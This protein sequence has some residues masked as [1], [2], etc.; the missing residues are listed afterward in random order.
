MQLPEDCIEEILEYLED[1]IITLHSCSLVSRTLCKIAIP[2][3]WRQPFRYKRHNPSSALIETYWNF[4]KKEYVTSEDKMIL[5]DFGIEI[6]QQQLK[7]KK[8]EI[9]NYPS[10][11][12]RLNS[13]DLYDFS[14]IWFI[15]S[16]TLVKPLT[17]EP[18]ITIA[19]CLFNTFIARGAK[20]EYLFWET[21]LIVFG[22]FVKYGHEQ[23]FN[24]AAIACHEIDTLIIGIRMNENYSGK[25]EKL[26]SLN[27]LI[28][29]Q[30]KLRE[31]I[32]AEYP[33]CTWD[34]LT[35]L[36]EVDISLDSQIDT[37][38]SIEFNNVDFSF[39]KPLEFVIRLIN[40]E[41]L[42]F[43]NCRNLEIVLEPFKFSSFKKL[44]KLVMIGYEGSN[45]IPLEL[46]NNLIGQTSETLNHLSI[47]MNSELTRVVTSAIQKYHP[48]LI[49]LFIKLD[50]SHFFILH[51]TRPF[52][53]LIKLKKL[54]IS[55]LGNLKVMT[56]ELLP[57]LGRS[58]PPNLLHLEIQAPWKF[59]IK[60][61]K[62]FL[63]NNQAPIKIFD[64][65]HCKDLQ[66]EHIILILNRLKNTLEKLIISD[67]CMNPQFYGR[68][69]SLRYRW[70]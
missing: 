70:E 56:D 4:L 22:C 57:Q 52:Y 68:V 59:S 3:L 13:R 9:F 65:R 41:N 44:K 43:K 5:S 11:I 25:E 38:T 42:I 53:N 67:E 28:N 17:P 37:L 35:R 6:S 32:F 48:E 1:D 54:V 36:R 39:W 20:F 8:E 30:N 69:D 49:E 60:S 18:M 66:D 31:F 46:L 7:Q 50:Q 14:L 24:N 51:K 26:E 45:N 62:K 61:L 23:T 2:I 34:T 15:S 12:K 55:S 64:I 33:G 58:L 10:F 29:A 27:K 63:D 47:V 40:L 19:R 16:K 21:E